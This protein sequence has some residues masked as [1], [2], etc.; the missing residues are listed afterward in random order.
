MGL[1]AAVIV[2]R[3]V[4]WMKGYG[5]ADRA[6]HA[7]VH[8]EHDHE[9]R[10]DRQALRRRG[11]DARGPRGE[12][13]ARRGHQQVPAV[14]GGQPAPPEREDHAPA[15]R[16]TYLRHH[17]PVGGLRGHLPLRRRFA[18][19]PRTLSR[20]VLRARRQELLARELPGR[21]AGRAPR[22]LQHRGRPRRV[23]RRAGLR[24]AAERLHAQ[25][26]LHAAADDAHGVV[27]VRGGPAR[28]TPR[29]SSRRMAS[30]FPSRSTASRPTR[31]EESAPRSRISRSSSSP[32]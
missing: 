28:I 27:P 26:H 14:P 3:Q 9:R 24:R 18:G 31:M 2:D 6:A 11:D 22:I 15:P 25:A 19:A 21:Q 5:F 12:A 7:A 17:G 29:C 4:V 8:P 10:L 23:H 1:G 32:C 16:D 20:A 30:P 13:L